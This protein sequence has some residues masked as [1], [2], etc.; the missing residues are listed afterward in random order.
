MG[1]TSESP[2]ISATQK[3]ERFFKTAGTAM[4]WQLINLSWGQPLTVLKTIK[5]LSPVNPSYVEIGRKIVAERGLTSLWQAAGTTL[6]QQLAKAGGRGMAANEIYHAMGEYFTE[7]MQQR[8]PLAKEITTAWTVAL[9]DSC[10]TTVMDV[11]RTR[12]IGHNI[13]A[14]GVF[15]HIWQNSAKGQM[16]QNYG[17]PGRLLASIADSNTSFNVSYAKLT[18]SWSS[19]FITQKISK[20][21]YKG[22]TGEEKLS[23]AAVVGSGVFSG[24]VK[25]GVSAP[26]DIIKT[27]KQNAEPSASGSYS[28]WS[29]AGK[30][31]QEQGV[32]G[33]FKGSGPRLAHSVAGCVGGAITMAIHNHTRE[34]HAETTWQEKVSSEDR[35][36]RQ[37]R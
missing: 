19:F 13:S 26:L 8:Y 37:A 24:V 20:D 21:I 17:I 25:V 11:V 31:W 29:V 23:P 32:R 7:D 12:Q 18:A 9:L 10:V 14:V 36:A 5:Q 33:F 3:A 30:I 28:I 15:Q 2:N 27:I 35:A 22:V 16:A 34:K 4:S 6:F 1:N